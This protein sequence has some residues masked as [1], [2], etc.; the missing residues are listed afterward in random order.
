MDDPR[1]DPFASKRVDLERP[2]GP[3]NVR[4]ELPAKI[5]K[6]KQALHPDTKQPQVMMGF[7]WQK[8]VAANRILVSFTTHVKEWTANVVKKREA[9]D[10]RGPQVSPSQLFST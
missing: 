5:L 1:F 8:R 3:F 4:E 10:K 7:D 9:L 6:W 2:D